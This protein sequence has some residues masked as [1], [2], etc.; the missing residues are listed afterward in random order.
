MPPTHLFQF[1]LHVTQRE[2]QRLE[3]AA[4]SLHVCGEARGSCLGRLMKKVGA[5]HCELQERRQRSVE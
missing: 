5:E 2:L 3:L 4:H 1:L